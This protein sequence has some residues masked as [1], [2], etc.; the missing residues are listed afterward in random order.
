[1]AAG[2]EVRHGREVGAIPGLR[3][4]ADQADGEVRFAS[5][6]WADEQDVGGGLEVAA[7]R[8]PADEGAVDAG[9]M[10]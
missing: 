2:G 10:S 8:E 6:R 7:G 5:T 1:M 4:G 9:A 3:R